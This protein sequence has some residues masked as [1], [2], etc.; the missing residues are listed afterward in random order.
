MS[1]VKSSMIEEENQSKKSAYSSKKM[2]L[3]KNENLNTSM[4]SEIDKMDI[5]KIREA[6]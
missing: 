3:K 6:M 4:I 5:S 2:S 1:S